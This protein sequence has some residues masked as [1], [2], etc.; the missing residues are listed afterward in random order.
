MRRHMTARTDRTNAPPL[1]GRAYAADYFV[2]E[3]TAAMLE[4]VERLKRT[5]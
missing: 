3:D 1:S 4:Y 5:N 2:D